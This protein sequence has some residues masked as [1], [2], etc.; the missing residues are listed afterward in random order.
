MTPGGHLVL[1]D[2]DGKRNNQI[3]MLSW[4]ATK[5]HVISFFF[6]FKSTIYYTGHVGRP[7]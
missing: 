4:S 3:G 1:G 6:F 2:G 5:L 7:W